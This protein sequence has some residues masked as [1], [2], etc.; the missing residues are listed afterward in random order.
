[1]MG[2]MIERFG[3]AVPEPAANVP[4]IRHKHTAAVRRC[5]V[6]RSLPCEIAHRPL[7]RGV[8]GVNLFFGMAVQC[9]FIVIHQPAEPGNITLRRH[10]LGDFLCVA[11]KGVI[12]RKQEEAQTNQ[13][14]CLNLVT[15]AVIVWHTVYM[16]AVLDQLQTEGY[17]VVEEDLAHLVPARFEHVKPYGKDVFPTDQ[18]LQ[19]P[20][21]RP[22]RT[23]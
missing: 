14:M 8:A 12:R 18:A 9:Q 20:G 13:A 2:E 21:L 22:L 11:A 15:N 6:E 1:M 23:A 19:R 5:R 3:K 16:Q 7:V 17:P 4:D 10:A